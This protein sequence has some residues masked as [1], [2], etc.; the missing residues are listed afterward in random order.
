VI[1]I[2]LPELEVIDRAQ[3]RQIMARYMRG[4]SLNILEA[5]C[6]RK[7]FF[8][9]G[10][11]TIT[12]VDMDPDAREHRKNV[13]KDLDRAVLGD[14]RTVPLPPGSYDVIYSSF[15]L[16][17]LDGAEGVLDRFVKALRP[18]GLLMLAF[19]DRD[20]VYGFFTRITPFWFHVF[21]KKYFEGYQNA[22][23]PGFSPFPTH[24]DEVIAR[25]NFLDNC[26]NNGLSVREE[27]G[28]HTVPRMVLRFIRI[29]GWLSFGKLASRHVN[30][31]CLLQKDS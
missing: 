16:E 10:D 6:G 1:S 25:G 23:K 28:F 20:S 12:G 21:Y 5:G 15:V 17:H 3:V 24:H 7:W 13:K 29:V 8:N 9:K 19:P 2:V 27:Y 30:L 31:M 18:G 14:L 22:G 26:A 11:H 4:K